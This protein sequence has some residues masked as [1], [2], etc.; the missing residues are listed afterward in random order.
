MTYPNTKLLECHGLL[1]QTSSRLIHKAMANNPDSSQRSFPSP[2]P[3]QPALC[4]DN[5]APEPLKRHTHGRYVVYADDQRDLFLEWWKRSDWG[6]Q[7]A[8]GTRFT[9]SSWDTASKSS[10]AWSF[11]DQVATIASG[12]P[13]VAC[14]FCGTVLKHPATSNT[15][16]STLNAHPASSGCKKKRKL[17]GQ[18]DIQTLLTKVGYQTRSSSACR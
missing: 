16:T 4:L 12:E 11:Y 17:V 7:K 1:S 8:A 3:S 2:E 10:Q 5:N 6:L 15:G 13:H 18:G 9:L 14:R